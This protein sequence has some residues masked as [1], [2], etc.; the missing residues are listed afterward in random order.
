VHVVDVVGRTHAGYLAPPGS[1]AGP[2]GV[3]ASG[4][5]P[6]V[7]VSAWRKFDRGDHVVV[8]YR[9]S[10]AVWEAVQVIGG[11]FGGP[12]KG[13][14]QLHLPRGL[15]FSG[16]GSGICVADTGNNRACVFRVADGGYV[17][18][19]ATGRRGRAPYDVEEVEGGW[20]TVCHGSDTVEFV[21]DGSV[22]GVGGGR[23]FLGK[24]GGGH[25]SGDGEFD[26]PSALAVVPGLGLVVREYFN[27][28]LQVFGTLDAIAMA[29]MSSMRVAW[30]GATAR[31]VL[32]RR[33]SVPPRARVWKRAGKGGSGP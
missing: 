3:A 16:S 29:S 6:L 25:G 27:E 9:G 14:G 2:R 26:G 1:I 8:V 20:L 23:P 22:G 31:A 24:A 32:C 13:E 28:C 21:C 4:T 11:V 7:A 12:G 33:V 18:H 30:M 5:S 10:G 17:R 15:R 19:M